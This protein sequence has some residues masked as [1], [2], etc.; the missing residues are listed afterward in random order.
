M[1]PVHQNRRRSS[2]HETV[3]ALG[4]REPH[5]TTGASLGA[6][7]D[8]RHLTFA[9]C[10]PEAPAPSNKPNAVDR[11]FF[12]A[13]YHKDGFAPRLDVGTAEEGPPLTG[14]SLSGSDTRPWQFINCS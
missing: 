3:V 14:L 13:V 7:A 6:F 4:C 5:R 9:G 12:T 11:F 2:Q 8:A 10:E 1:E